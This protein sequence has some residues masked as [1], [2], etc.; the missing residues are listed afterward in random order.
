MSEFDMTPQLTL[1]PEA[2]PEAPVVP[3]LN[4]EPEAQLE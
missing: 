1:T 3:E 4:M 2:E